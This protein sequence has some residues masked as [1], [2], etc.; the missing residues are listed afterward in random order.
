MAWYNASWLKRKSITLT[1]G[2]SGSQTNFQLKLT[3]TYDSDMQ[4]DFDDL[5]FTQSDGTTLIDAWLESK[6]NSTS[7]VVYVEFPTTPANTVEQTYYMYYGNSGVASAWSG[8][9]TFAFYDDFNRT[10]SA[11]VGNSWV[12]TESGGTC[13]I[14]T[15]RLK[16]VTS[17]SSHAY[18]TRD[19][20]GLGLSDF[21]AEA[22]IVVSAISGGTNNRVLH[23]VYDGDMSGDT[24]IG[25]G[26]VSGQFVGQK[27]HTYDGAYVDL[28]APVANGTYAKYGISYTLLSAEEHKLWAD[29]AE[30]RNV[31]SRADYTNPFYIQ[32]YQLSDA[33]DSMT[34]YV[35][36][37][38][39]RKYAINPPTCGFGS[40][41]TGGFIPRVIMF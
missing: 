15:N 21:V 34:S 2:A 32:L 7:A 19:F 31:T 9:N 28:G 20:T 40:E 10:D 35:D 17:G 4:A 27:M 16:L 39:V 12:E 13:S 22:D 11:T 14:D 18:V 30:E 24:Y 5:R 38:R 26:S 25:N 36:C 33:G 1:G 8:A 23:R 6:V 3:V 29:D 41:E 37:Y